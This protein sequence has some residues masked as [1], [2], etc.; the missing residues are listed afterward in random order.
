MELILDK[1]QSGK[2]TND[3]ETFSII[4]YTPLA[5]SSNLLLIK[6][7]TIGLEDKEETQVPSLE[8]FKVQFIASCKIKIAEAVMVAFFVDEYNSLSPFVIGGLPSNYIQ[9][10]ERFKCVDYKA[11]TEIAELT[12]ETKLSLFDY[13][14][15]LKKD[16]L[17]LN[18][19]IVH[20]EKSYNFDQQIE[21]YKEIEAIKLN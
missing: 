17:G 10:H 14:Q 8:I 7:G 12:G 2:Q 9:A 19:F 11:Y 20:N 16:A 18:S 1:F 13:Y 5:N 15:M 4:N 6:E 21:L 3:R